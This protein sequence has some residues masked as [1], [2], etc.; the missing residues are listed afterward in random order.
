MTKAADEEEHAG[1]TGSADR[2]SFDLDD[3]P[4]T[5]PSAHPEVADLCALTL[6]AA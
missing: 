1:T 6:L 5:T 4:L 3:L 2:R